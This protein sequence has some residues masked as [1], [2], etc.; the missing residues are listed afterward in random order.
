[1]KTESQGEYLSPSKQIKAIRKNPNE[2]GNRADIF[3]SYPHLKDGDLNENGLHNVEFHSLYSSTNIVR[4]IR[5]R[6]LRWAGY[7]ARMKYGRSAFKILHANLQ[8]RHLSEGL[9]EERR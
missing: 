2:N 9:G 5:S 7:E 3:G 8:E 4:V 6:R 1:M